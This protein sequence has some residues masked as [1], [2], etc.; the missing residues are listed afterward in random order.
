MAYRDEGQGTPIFLIHGW[1]VSGSSFQAQINGLS[2]RYRVVAPDL[3]GH[4]ASDEFP[5][6]GHF[7]IF[8]EGIAELISELQLEKFCLVGWS[9]GAMVAWNLLLCH[10][11]INASGLVTIDMVPR[12]LNEHGW[13]HGLLDT[14]KA[15]VFTPSMEFMLGDWPAYTA[16]FVPRIFSATAN[17]ETQKLIEQTTTV[18]LVNDPLKMARIWSG[19]CEQDFRAGLP[20]IGL[21]TL[22]VAGRHSQLYSIAASEWVKR[23]I[24]QSR[25][26]VFS[27]SGHAPQMEEPAQFNQLLSEFVDSLN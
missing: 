26:E 13:S 2:D 27:H 21:P 17:P 20:G 3:R 7:S 16:W 10:P 11:E 6:D 4:G 19:M 14:D 22:V 25:L 23:Q 1:G 5:V 24:P 15:H 8:A 9:M 12:V 18:S